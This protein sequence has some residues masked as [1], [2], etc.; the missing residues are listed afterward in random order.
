MERSIWINL[1]LLKYKPQQSSGGNPF[2]F[3]HSGSGRHQRGHTQRPY[4]VMLE[5]KK[6]WR[7]GKSPLNGITTGIKIFPPYCHTYG[8]RHPCM[9]Y[10]LT[11]MDYSIWIN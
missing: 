5:L 7:V 11:R 6:E 4:T 1:I 2:L 9:E 10:G 8:I 3:H